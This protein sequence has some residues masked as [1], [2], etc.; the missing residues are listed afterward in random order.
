M[1]FSGR[2]EGKLVAQMLAPVVSAAPAA[3]S[4]ATATAAVSTAA[5]AAKTPAPILVPFSAAVVSAQ[6]LAPM[7]S[8]LTHYPWLEGP[9]PLPTSLPGR[10]KMTLLCR[11]KP[12]PG[13]P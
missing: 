5:P 8:S 3:G 9:E 13:R 12:I 1:G 10:P 11:P 2:I 4:E 6:A 7:L